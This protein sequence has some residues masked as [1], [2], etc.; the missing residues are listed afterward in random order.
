MVHHVACGHLIEQLLCAGDFCLLNWTQLKAFHCAFRFG[1]KEN[2]LDRTFIES[3]CPVRRI[4]S[5]RCRDLEG[6]RQLGINANFLRCIQILGK[7]SLDA[8]V[9]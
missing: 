1:Y 4:V 2:V 9:S 7:F 3:D 8:L 6:S 5:Y